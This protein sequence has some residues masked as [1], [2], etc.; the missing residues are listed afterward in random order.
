MSARVSKVATIVASAFFAV[1]LW[2]A[3]TRADTLEVF[4]ALLNGAQE[5]PPV[6]SP[7]TGV[8]VVY[9][10]KNT[11]S[12]CWRIS[13]TP[14]AG[15]EVLAHFHGPATPGANAGVVVDISPPPAGPSPL[16]SPK[17]GCATITKDEAKDLRKGLWYIN[18]HSTP[19]APSGEIRGQVFPQKGVK[20]KSD[21]LASPSGAF[22]D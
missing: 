7:S 17:H 22:L 5:N 15:T 12:L 1:A 20:Y 14:L 6:A 4:T 19:F 13:F 10:N 2:A 16:G 11:L 3:P 9:L 18:I 8:A 21:A